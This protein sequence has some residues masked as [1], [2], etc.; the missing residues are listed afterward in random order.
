MVVNTG[1]CETETVAENNSWACHGFETGYLHDP[2]AR[3]QIIRDI[4]SVLPVARI[5]GTVKNFAGGIDFGKGATVSLFSS[6]NGTLIAQTFASETDATYSFENVPAP[7]PDCI[8]KAKSALVNVC[9][10]TSAPLLPGNNYSADI[11]LTE[12]CD[13][14]PSVQYF[15]TTAGNPGIPGDGIFINADGGQLEWGDFIFELQ[16]Y[17]SLQGITNG[18]TVS[19][20]SQSDI[21][22]ENMSIGVIFLVKN[23]AP[24]DCSIGIGFY[25]IASSSVNG[26]AG[27]AANIRQ[28]DLNF[29]VSF[30]REYTSCNQV[31]L[32]DIVVAGIQAIDYTDAPSV[33]F[34]RRLDAV[35][36]GL[37]ENAFPR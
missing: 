33:Q 27:R 7:C 11:I 13:I 4:K 22:P 20:F 21:P 8:V 30:F 18:I 12:T 28:D 6:P 25:V 32:S 35:A 36:I 26:V 9:G 5:Y 24:S 17:F 3:N 31:S 1:L 14:Q 15:S 29:A 16:P 23:I 37:G 10:N 19:V 34:I 2:E